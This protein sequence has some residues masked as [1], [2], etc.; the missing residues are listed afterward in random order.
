MVAKIIK[1]IMR[2]YYFLNIIL[3]VTLLFLGCSSK[4]PEIT[5]AR[6]IAG[7]DRFVQTGDKVIL[8][9]SSDSPDVDSFYWSFIAWPGDNAP[10]LEKIGTRGA[11]FI[12]DSPGL[13]VLKL[14]VKIGDTEGIPD[15]VNIYSKMAVPCENNRDNDQD[16]YDAVECGGTDCNDLDKDIHPGVEEI[17]GDGIDQD[18]DGLDLDCD[19][20]DQ[21]QDGFKDAACG[22]KDCDDTKNT[23]NPL[24]Q[25]GCNGMDD[26]CDG[27]IDSING[28][29]LSRSCYTG[30]SSTVDKGVC[31]EGTEECING[32]WSGVCEGEVL[33]SDEI[34]DGLDNDCDLEV[35]ED[36][37]Q[38]GQSCITGLG[39]DCDPGTIICQNGELK[40]KSNIGWY[41]EDC[42]DGVDNDCDGLVDT[43]DVEDCGECTDGSTRECGID[44]GICQKGQ[45]QCNSGFWSNCMGAT[46]PEDEVCNGLDDD[47]D[48]EV[49]EDGVCPTGC[50]GSTSVSDSCDP[51]TPCD[52][53]LF[54]D[55]TRYYCASINGEGYNY[56]TEDELNCSQQNYCLLKECGGKGYYCDGTDW[57]P[58]PPPEEQCNGIDDNCDGNLMSGEEDL[59]QDGYLACNNDCDD[60]DP[61]IHPGAQERCNGKD[62]NCDNILPQSEKD[63]D[64]DGVMPC[65]GDCNDQDPSV[66][67]GAVELCDGKDNDCD[68]VVDEGGVCPSGCSGTDT[69]PKECNNTTECN[70]CLFYNNNKY[71]CRSLNSGTFIY[72]KEGQPTCNQSRR[73]YTLSCSNTT[74][75]CNGTEWVDPATLT[76]VCNGI[77][78]DCDGVVP[79][80]EKDMDQDGYSPCEGD[81]DDSN[82]DI[83]PGATEVCNGVDDDCDNQIDEEN[84]V[85]CVTYYYDGD[86][87]NYGTSDNS[88]CLCAPEGSYR[89]QQN[90]DCNDTDPNIYPGATEVCNGKDD[91]CNYIIDE[92][93][94]TGCTVYYKDEDGDGFGVDSDYKCLCTPTSIYSTETGGDCLD[95]DNAVHPG[96]D[97]T[98]GNANGGDYNC[99]G[100]VEFSL[101]NKCGAFSAGWKDTVPGCGQTSKYCN[102]TCTCW[103]NSQRTQKCR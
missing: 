8:F 12:A 11:A 87:D 18:C 33:P 54:V 80:P 16:G 57:K 9:G 99:D 100:V 68:N 103:D 20:K 17:C 22:G 14:T 48:G 43:Q 5:R 102:L 101:P 26:N 38:K 25:E 21:D 6:A 34:C 32:N 75:V 28:V 49:D 89:T 53:C 2:K 85:Y 31:K 60:N 1:M 70:S 98:A 83:Y 58:L 37:P 65:Q 90:G 3:A 4:V 84:A 55:N 47:C 64:S 96:A 29:A 79:D 77:D 7:P 88:R 62:D 67:Y 94:A 81:C 73:C 39:G 78:D 97:F 42:Y 44:I 63:K 35:D 95:T 71:F 93:N 36:F 59:D 24:M 13:Y 41:P 46:L 40:C 74:L 91:N 66:Y 27:E 19:C 69:P 76:E 52:E 30:D 72:Y 51:D 15:F 92:K 82:P 23:I 56:H 50:T 61:D 86:H 45:R 10:S